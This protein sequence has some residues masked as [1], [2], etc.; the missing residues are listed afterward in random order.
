V[1]P[2]V[3]PG[4]VQPKTNQSAIDQTQARPARAFPQC[5]P[6]CKHAQESDRTI[7]GGLILPARPM[8]RF[9][10]RR[11]REDSFDAIG[12][13]YKCLRFRRSGRMP[14]CRDAIPQ[15]SR[16]AV[17]EVEQNAQ[18]PRSPFFCLGYGSRGFP[19][20]SGLAVFN[21]VSA[22]CV[23]PKTSTARSRGDQATRCRL[24]PG[25]FN[26]D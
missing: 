8:L 11:P 20:K 3:L 5:E 4:S 14:A 13:T 23:L 15:S 12:Q 16:K 18:H 26:R 17:F 10:P 1:C 9:R 7:R 6:F 2:I 25:R 19:L 24:A 22:F 21:Q